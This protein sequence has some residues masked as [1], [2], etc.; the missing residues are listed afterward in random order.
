MSEHT[1]KNDVPR[2]ATLEVPMDLKNKLK[3]EAA[4]KNVPLK[5]LTERFL[6]DAL[7]A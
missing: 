2:L 5:A 7:A 6:R 1:E 4:R 3:V